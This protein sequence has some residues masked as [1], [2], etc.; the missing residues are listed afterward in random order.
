M[1][2]QQYFDFFR[3]RY[4]TLFQ[5]VHNMEVVR[6]V[7]LVH[8]N[9]CMPDIHELVCHRI[10]ADEIASLMNENFCYNHTSFLLMPEVIFRNNFAAF[11]IFACTLFIL[12]L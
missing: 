6:R 10:Y 1:Q 2:L 4:K 3:D 9:I 8:Y 11:F 7:N 5:L 12:I